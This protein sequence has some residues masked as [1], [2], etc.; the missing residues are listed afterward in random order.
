M[1]V[2][3]RCHCGAIR[4]EID[5]PVE[6]LV[7]CHC[8]NCRRANGGAF[9]TITPVIGDAFRIIAGTDFLKAFETST[10]HRYFC[11][12][13][14]GRLFSRPADAPEYANVLVSTL[15]EEPATA[16]S[17]HLNCESKAPW[18]KIRDE[19]PQFAS[20]PEMPAPPETN[21]NQEEG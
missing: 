8:R 13:C 16:P 6:L 4:I 3:G 18:Y 10:G 2:T 21:P 5:H 15:D 7:N 14:G 9:S 19:A 12:I 11:E 17:V 20:I 1:S